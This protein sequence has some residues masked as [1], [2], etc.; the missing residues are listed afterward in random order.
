MS[1]NKNV[2]KTYLIISFV[3]YLLLWTYSKKLF[4]LRVVTPP[5]P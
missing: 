3:V 4:W 2:I 5:Y 1:K